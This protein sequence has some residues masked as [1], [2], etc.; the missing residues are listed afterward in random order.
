M[1]FRQIFRRD[2]CFDAEDWIIGKFLTKL[3]RKNVDDTFSR[4]D[5]IP[6]RD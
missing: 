6:A 3:V 5:T 1:D 4:F 2:I